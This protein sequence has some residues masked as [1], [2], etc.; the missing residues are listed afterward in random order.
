MVVCCKTVFADYRVK[1]GAV[2]N[3]YSMHIRQLDYS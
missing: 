1:Y 3:S 2:M